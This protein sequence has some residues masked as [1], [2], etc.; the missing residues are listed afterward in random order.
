VLSAGHASILQYA[1]LHLSGYDLTLDDLRSFRHAGS[2]TPG[3]PERGHTDGV[4]V[5]T[6]PLGQGIS[7]AVGLTIAERRSRRGS[8]ARITPS[9]TTAPGSSPA[10]GT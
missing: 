2:R 7:M 1:A 6:G 3:H 4:E 9:S 8:T 5:T 10:T